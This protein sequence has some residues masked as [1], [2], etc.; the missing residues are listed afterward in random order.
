MEYLT[1]MLKIA[2][3]ESRKLPRSTDSLQWYFC[4]RSFYEGYS[5]SACRFCKHIGEKIM[6]IYDTNGIEAHQESLEI[7]EENCTL[8]F[9]FILYKEHENKEPTIIQIE[10][11][12]EGKCKIVDVSSADLEN[13]IG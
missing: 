11:P 4:N 7:P 1:S 12:K 2:N 6:K 13:L 9:M 3:L 8:H 5:D 10:D